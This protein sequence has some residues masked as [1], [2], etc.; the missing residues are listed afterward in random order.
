MPFLKEALK[1]GVKAVTKSGGSSAAKDLAGKT[2]PSLGSVI[3]DVQKGPGTKRFLI[4]ENGAEI[5]TTTQEVNA[6]CRYFGTEERMLQFAA[7]DEASQYMMAVSSLE[8]HLNRQKAL[9]GTTVKK[10]GGRPFASK[11][12]L[13]DYLAQQ[14]Q[15]VKNY[16]LE[17]IEMQLIKKPQQ[18]YLPKR[19]ADILEAAGEVEF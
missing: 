10:T 18:M 4:M 7:A 12:M 11:A 19:Y 15:V 6:L 2:L 5:P 13:D 1:A 8:F 9:I 17:P 3:K 16:G 14:N